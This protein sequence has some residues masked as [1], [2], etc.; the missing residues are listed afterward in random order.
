MSPSRNTGYDAST[1][2]SFVE[3]DSRL[4]WT[5]GYPFVFRALGVGGSDTPKTLLDYGCGPGRV[6]NRIARKYDIRVIAV[7]P[8]TEMLTIASQRY[9]HPR[10]T[11]RQIRDN[12]LDFLADTSIDAMPRSLS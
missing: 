6:A 7:D 10:I 12:R 1:S 9:R 3:V 5:L 2:A 4:G 11:Y 8:S